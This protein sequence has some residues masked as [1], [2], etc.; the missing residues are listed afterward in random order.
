MS[1]KSPP[2]PP[3]GAGRAA[4]AGSPPGAAAAQ[5]AGAPAARPA[6]ARQRPAV[7]R[8][9]LLAGAALALAAGLWGGLARLEVAPAPREAFA[10]EHGPLMAL[11][12]LGT[13]IALERA[14]SL[15]RRWAY[16]APALGG[17]GAIAL[18]A[19]L[20]TAGRLAL[21]A[22]A[23]WL[24]ACYVVVVLERRPG[25]AVGV[26]LTGALAWYGGGL[27]WLR[28][29]PV[30]DLVPWL[31]AFLVLTIA[32]ERLELAHAA[33][34]RRRAAD[35]LI[36]TAGLLVAGVLTAVPLPSAGWRIT[37]VGMLA[38]AAW[39]GVHDVARRTVRAAGLTRF[40]AVCLL[41]GY[42]WLAVG[43]LLWAVAGRPDGGLY[44]AALHAVFLGFVM[45]MVFGHAPVILPAVLRVRL[46]YRPAMY[47]PLALLHLALAARV[48]GDLAGF[49]P[50]RAAG[51]VLGEVALVA[52]ACC[53][54]AAAVRARRSGTGE[55][56]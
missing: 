19:G 2:A 26:Q 16:V 4:S 39:L 22:A 24:V 47:G 8:L 5:A 42:A 3:P 33:F 27:L 56:S 48:A 34:L 51:G 7:A 55:P 20:G 1:Q 35:G 15:R 23:G 50:A 6:M 43:G 53:A 46:P 37:G 31:A 29:H 25:R 11:G 54:A 52:F 18:A 14:V 13:L 44:D 28:G 38:L 9:P 40:S 32:G 12:F 49:E 36:A 17:L 41:G 10:A 30:A 21:T 45:S